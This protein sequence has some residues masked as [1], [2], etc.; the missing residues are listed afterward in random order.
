MTDRHK[1][2]RDQ[3]HRLIMGWPLNKPEPRPTTERGA[4]EA[5]HTW[6]QPPR[7]ELPTREEMDAAA[8]RLIDS[9]RDANKTIQ[10]QSMDW[11]RDMASKVSREKEQAVLEALITVMVAT[12]RS[13]IRIEPRHVI[14]VRDYTLHRHT[15]PVTGDWLL[16]LTRKDA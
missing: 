7:Y 16:E 1:S 8:K 11:A 14:N 9:S 6:A 12:D 13:V 15:D 2:I 3:M 5:V 10:E 4:P